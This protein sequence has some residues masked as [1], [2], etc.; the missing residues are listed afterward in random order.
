MARVY[1]TFWISIFDGRNVNKNTQ[2]AE[3]MKQRSDKYMKINGHSW[4]LHFK[5]THLRWETSFIVCTVFK[6]PIQQTSLATTRNFLNLLFVS[7]FAFCWIFFHSYTYLFKF[8]ITRNVN[9]S[10]LLASNQK[11]NS[12][13]IPNLTISW[14]DIFHENFINF[15]N[16]FHD[17]QSNSF[18]MA[19]LKTRKLLLHWCY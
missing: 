8:W 4:E 11:K 12:I 10:S 18:L 6:I 2:E 13:K 1:S 16:C 3:I 14:F 15:G 5:F 7:L 9:S 19:L 17:I